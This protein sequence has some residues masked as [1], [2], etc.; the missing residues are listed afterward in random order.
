MDRGKS[1]IAWSCLP[2]PGQS[3]NSAEL[4]TKAGAVQRLFTGNG[5][6]HNLSLQAIT[7]PQLASV[8]KNSLNTNL[9]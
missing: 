8:A 6:Q 4:S 1:I 7:L 9:S 2:D 3:N 5:N